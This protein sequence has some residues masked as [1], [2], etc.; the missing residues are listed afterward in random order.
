MTANVLF[1]LF[2]YHLGCDFNKWA[3]L[4]SLRWQDGIRL[5]M[6][7]EVF[8]NGSLALPQYHTHNNFD[9]VFSVSLCVETSA[10]HASWSHI[11]SVRK[12]NSDDTIFPSLFLDTWPAFFPTGWKEATVFMFPIRRDMCLLALHCLSSYH[13]AQSDLT[14]GDRKQSDSFVCSTIN[15]N[16]KQGGK[17]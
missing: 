15:A 6:S 4:S 17:T 8:R 3:T 9:A 16:I 11:I 1:Y 14:E 2:F 10:V 13:R 12:R 5:R 7:L